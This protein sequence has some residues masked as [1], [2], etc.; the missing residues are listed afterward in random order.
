MFD[1]LIAAQKE[2]V[3]EGSSTAEFLTDTRVVHTV[4]DMFGGMFY[5]T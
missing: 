5:S 2:A 1:S 3:A 4:A